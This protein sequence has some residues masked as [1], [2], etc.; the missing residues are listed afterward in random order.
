ML[1]T[2]FPRHHC[3]SRVGVWPWLLQSNASLNR[4]PKMKGSKDWEESFLA[5]RAIAMMRS[6]SWGNRGAVPA[7]VSSVWDPLYHS[8][9]AGLGHSDSSSAAILP[10]PILQCNFGILFLTAA[11]LGLD[12][13]LLQS[14]YG[15]L[16]RFSFFWNNPESIS[17]ACLPK[18]WL[19]LKFSLYAASG[20]DVCLER[21]SSTVVKGTNAIL[22]L[23]HN[24][25][26]LLKI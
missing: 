2:H 21:F 13:Q 18:P 11:P 7:S 1:Q 12:F 17:V 19:I 25:M 24:S 5:E 16:V 10:G 26:I 22:S 8:L 14:S 9:S 15:L 6:S 3:W 23:S 20:L 4:G